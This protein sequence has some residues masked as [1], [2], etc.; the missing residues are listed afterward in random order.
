MAEILH[1]LGC[2][3][4]YMGYPPYQ[5]VQ[6]FSH[7]QYHACLR[8][9]IP[10]LLYLDHLDRNWQSKVDTLSSLARILS[11]TL[12]ITWVWKNHPNRTG[13]RTPHGF[14]SWFCNKVVNPHILLQ[15]S[16]TQFEGFTQNPTPEALWFQPFKPQEHVN[17]FGKT[18]SDEKTSSRHL[19]E[20]E[21]MED[22]SFD[23][24]FYLEEI[25]FSQHKRHKQ[26]K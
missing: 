19:V 14:V 13:W 16:A 6:D 12:P 24:S 20:I 4:P 17:L 9:P 15:W 23:L 7:Q 2:M 18:G 5:L 21:A 22:S 11:K 26:T 25:H 10:N 1:H 8:T 3:K